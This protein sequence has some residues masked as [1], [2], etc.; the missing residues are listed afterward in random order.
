MFHLNYK[1]ITT[2]P[3][4]NITYIGY[5]SKS[6]VKDLHKNL[7]LIRNK[8]NACSNLRKEKQ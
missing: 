8:K 6:Y 2:T 4:N 3:C 1:I 7:W 5:L